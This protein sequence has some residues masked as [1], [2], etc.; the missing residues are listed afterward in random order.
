[1]WV[2]TKCY[3]PLSKQFRR[4]FAS[5]FVVELHKTCKIKNPKK[6]IAEAPSP[7]F[8]SSGVWAI[9]GN[10]DSSD[11]GVCITDEGATTDPE[12][13]PIA[14]QCCDGETC[15]REYEGACISGDYDQDTTVLPHMMTF[16]EAQQACQQRGLTLCDQSCKGAGCR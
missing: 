13:I 2:A 4:N 11:E 8:P 7:A 15:Y 16:S 9:N 6:G 14:A 10:A 5:I 12:G 3:Q 1:M